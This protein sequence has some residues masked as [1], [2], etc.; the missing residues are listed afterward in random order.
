MHMGSIRLWVVSGFAVI[1]IAVA[2]AAAADPIDDA[3]CTAWN[4]NGSCYYSN[5][6]AAKAAGHC[7]IPEGS[8][9]YCPSQ[10]RDGDGL[11]CE[12]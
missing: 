10:D 7:D 8:E 6:S 1:G 3:A 9:Y 4:A 5:C 11:A 2:P 12:C